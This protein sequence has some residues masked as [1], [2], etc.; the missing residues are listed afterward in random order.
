MF[1][2]NIKHETAPSF[3]KFSGK[4]KV[5]LR[6]EWERVINIIYKC[7]EC[8]VA[9]VDEI[10]LE[11]VTVLKAIM[12]R[13]KCDWVRHIFNCL[14]TFILKAITPSLGVI[15]GNMGFGFLVT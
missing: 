10:T 5:M 7:W 1:W 9:G 11:N 12:P 13:Y 8:I 15:S 3:V 2:D 14:G 6:P 4:K